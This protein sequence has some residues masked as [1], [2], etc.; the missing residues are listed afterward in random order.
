MP[1]RHFLMMQALP[2]DGPTLARRGQ[3]KKMGGFFCFQMRREQ[4]DARA[5]RSAL[6]DEPEGLGADG[7]G[8][9]RIE[10]NKEAWSARASKT[11]CSANGAHWSPISGNARRK[12]GGVAKGVEIRQ[13]VAMERKQWKTGSASRGLQVDMASLCILAAL[14]AGMMFGLGKAARQDA[15]EQG[16]AVAKAA[17]NSEAALAE[18]PIAPEPGESIQDLAKRLV[19]KDTFLALA[20]SVEDAPKRAYVDRAGANVGA[21]YCIDARRKGLGESAVRAD[22]ALAGFAVAEIGKLMSRNKRLI[23]SVEVDSKQALRLLAITKPQYEALAREAV[24]ADFFEELPKHKQD[25]LS[26]LSYNTGGAKKFVN[27][28]KAVKKR[29]DMAALAEMAPKFRVGGSN[30]NPRFRLNHRLRAWAQAAWMGPEFLKDALREPDQFEKSYAGS[31]GQDK[32]IKNHMAFFDKLAQNKARSMSTA[33]E[34]EKP[35]E[36][37]R[38]VLKKMSTGPKLALSQN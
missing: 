28:L 22:L 9:K 7:K 6:G 1:A 15:P 29:D 5:Q 2:K 35:Q 38:L 10:G 16:A 18:L 27:L 13:D 19:G 17:E 33:K 21:G 31:S 11:E 12:W 8:A 37:V 23:E 4:L 25:V 24:G 30:S 26:Y 34:A 14:S 32:F 36:P 20:L 3:E